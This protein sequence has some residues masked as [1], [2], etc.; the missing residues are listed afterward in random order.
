MLGAI[1]QFRKDGFY[2]ARDLIDSRE[3]A[4][5]RAGLHKSFDDQLALFG[6]RGGEDIFASMRS[7][8]RLDVDRYRKVVG[9]LWRKVEV[10]RL[11]HHPD[12]LRVLS[13]E[14]GWKDMFVPG[15]Q[16]VHIMAEELKIPGG[17][18][19]LAPHQ[20]YP[21]VQGSLD[22]VVVWLPLVD[23]DRDNYPLEVIPGSHLDGLLPATEN[24]ES[25]W[26]A[27]DSR[28]PEDAYV[29]AEVNVGD[30]I[31]MSLFTVHRSS[32]RGKPGRLRL[33]LSTRF[34]DADEPTFV[35]RAYPSAYI[36][37]VHREQYVKGFP[38]PG[39]VAGL[40]RQR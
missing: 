7:L 24:R 10:Y 25:T 29:P 36:R 37:T 2:I 35:E 34:D 27:D 12:I 17:Y 6:E 20:D 18:F 15:G 9:A 16:V 32:C 33:A 11:M 26:E 1:E 4:A 21:S 22:G 40:F 19:G 13:D 28:Y 23:V 39:Q 31:F 14:F 38:T 30:V 8:H 5:V 3:I